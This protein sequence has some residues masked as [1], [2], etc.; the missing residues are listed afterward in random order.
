MD[1]ETSVL[2]W[3]HQSRSKTRTWVLVVHLGGDSR[4]HSEEV[5]SMRQAGKGEKPEN[6]FREKAQPKK[7][8]VHPEMSRLRCPHS[9]FLPQGERRR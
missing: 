5:Q 9:L 1:E 8:H 3:V 7:V 2:G 4:E 6:K